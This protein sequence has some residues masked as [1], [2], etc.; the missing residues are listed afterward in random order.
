MTDDL[1]NEFYCDLLDLEESGEVGSVEESRR[2]DT[3]GRGSS[4]RASVSPRRQGGSDGG[5]GRWSPPV[6]AK[7]KHRRHDGRKEGE[8]VSLEIAHLSF[9]YIRLGKNIR[10]QSL[11]TVVPVVLKTN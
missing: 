4:Q 1:V 7:D 11:A 8:G 9:I 10:R 6:T 3:G 2:R 5:G